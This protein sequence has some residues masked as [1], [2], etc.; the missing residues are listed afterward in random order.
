MWRDFILLEVIY[1]PVEVGEEE[2]IEEQIDDDGETLIF[3]E[4]DL[5]A[6]QEVQAEEPRTKISRSRQGKGVF[7]KTDFLMP[8]IFRGLGWD[9][10]I[11]MVKKT[12]FF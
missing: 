10:D 9:F 8:L 3:A 7:L 12:W 4:D 5:D 2:V 1:E 6:E 11:R